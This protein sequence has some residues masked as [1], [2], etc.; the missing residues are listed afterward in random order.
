MDLADLSRKGC[1]PALAALARVHP[2]PLSASEFVEASGMDAG[3]AIR[4]RGD[5]EELGILMVDIVREQGSVR[6]YAISLASVG[7][8]LVP[9]ILA[10]EDVLTKH[11]KK[12]KGGRK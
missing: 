12:T 2:R 1:L 3:A 7:R 9:H 4:L 5:L 11:A 10:L 6:V 8:D